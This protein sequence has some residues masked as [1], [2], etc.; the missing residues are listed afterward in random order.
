MSVSDFLPVS[1]T[2]KH[3]DRLNFNLVSEIGKSGL[4]FADIYIHLN[5]EIPPKDFYMFVYHSYIFDRKKLAKIRSAFNKAI[6]SHRYKAFISRIYEY[7]IEYYS[8]AEIAKT[9]NSTQ[10]ELIKFTRDQTLLIPIEIICKLE[11][12]WN[13]HGTQSR[14]SLLRHKTHSKESHIK[15]GSSC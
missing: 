2:Q 5:N 13:T 10:K 4:D 15:E 12:F 3:L 14:C 9:I 6:Q 7:L 11:D 1:M 8:L